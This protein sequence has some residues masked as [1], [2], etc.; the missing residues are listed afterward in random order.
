[1]VPANIKQNKK[2]MNER[3][4]MK[5]S[6]ELEG[7]AFRNVSGCGPQWSESSAVAGAHSLLQGPETGKE[8]NYR[9]NKDDQVGPRGAD[10]DGSPLIKIKYSL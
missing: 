4:R 6:S 8:E 5:E 9:M 3:E 1:M 2:R 10:V 7:S